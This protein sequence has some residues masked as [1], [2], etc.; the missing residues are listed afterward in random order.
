MRVVF[1]GTPEFAVPSL[2]QLLESHHEVAA[3]FTQ[4]DKPAGRGQRLH[5]PPVKVLARRAGLTVFQPE[6]IRDHANRPILEKLAPDCLVVVAYG[7][8]LPGWLLGTPRMG[9]VNLHASLLPRYRGAA[10]IPWAI[11]NGDAVTGVTTMLLDEGM[12]TGPILLQEEIRLDQAWNA[13]D[14]AEQLAGIG[15]GLLLRSLAGLERAA[16]EPREQEE[17]YASYAPRIFKEMARIEWNCGA[18]QIH[19]K[20]RAMNPWPVGYSEFREQKVKIFSSRLH[21]ASPPLEGPEGSLV[22]LTPEGFVVQCGGR[23]VLEITDLQVEGRRRINGRE[24]INGA[25][26]QRGEVVF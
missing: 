11:M 15:A 3:V 9:A 25:R 1:L 24:F 12:D 18:E 14:L 13:Q 17:E 7:Q 6:R 4:P 21:A 5:A 16:I 10:P 19:N 26:L 20:I 8:L 2:S 22:E 23:T